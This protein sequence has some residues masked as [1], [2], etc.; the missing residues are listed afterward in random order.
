ME[1][2]ELA[3]TVDRIAGTPRRWTADALAAE[4]NLFDDLRTQLAI[5]TIG[6]IDVPKA[7]R[8]QRRA[9]RKREREREVQRNKRLEKGPKRVPLTASQPWRHQGVSRATYYRHMRKAERNETK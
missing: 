8:A 3:R 1:P 7:M 6:A 5:R 4:L 9:D 2:A